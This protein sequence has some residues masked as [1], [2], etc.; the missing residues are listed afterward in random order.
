MKTKY[1][2]CAGI[3]LLTLL[4]GCSLGYDV[5]TDISDHR[6]KYNKNGSPDKEQDFDEYTAE[7]EKKITE[8]RLAEEQRIKNATRDFPTVDA[9]GETKKENTTS[10]D[11]GDEESTA[12]EMNDLEN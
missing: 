12:S 2:L 1:Y 4:S 6:N 9:K 11:T 8:E 5:L 10:G 7:R 3:V